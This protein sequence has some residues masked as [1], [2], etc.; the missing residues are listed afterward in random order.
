[1]LEQDR[2]QMVIKRMQIACWIPNGTNTRSEYIMLTAFS[3][4]QWLR[5]RALVLR[6]TYIA[7]SC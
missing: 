4:Q 2:P 1:M 3:W 5:E 7:L 6:Y